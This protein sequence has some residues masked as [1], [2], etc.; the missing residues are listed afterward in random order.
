[1]VVHDELGSLQRSGELLLE[2]APLGDLLAELAVVAL[3]RAAA[4]PLAVV[5]RRIG[6]AEERLR[7]HPVVREEA[8]PDTHLGQMLLA[9]EL[10]R[11][12]HGPPEPFSRLHHLSGA[13]DVLE[14]NRELVA[15]EVGDRVAVPDDGPQAAGDLLEELIADGMPVRVVDLVESVEVQRQHR[16]AVAV[17]RRRPD[18]LAEPLL[19]SH[20]VG[21][22]GQRVVA[23]ELMKGLVGALPL[24]D[25]VEHHHV[26]GLPLP[27]ARGD[28]ELRDA[29]LPV[30]PPDGHL[31]PRFP[32][33]GYAEG[34]APES[35]TGLSELSLCGGIRV[36]DGAR[37]VDEEDTDGGVLH[38]LAEVLPTPPPLPLES[39]PLLGT[40]L[41]RL[42]LRL[43]GMG[44]SPVHES[45]STPAASPQNAATRA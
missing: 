25:V 21:Q 44:G 18:G 32:R 19:Q 39:A 7:V 30:A 10:D 35:L 24:R 4:E 40:V 13:V 9:G 1:M 26:A 41:A 15:A 37:L 22:L 2:D 43:V 29:D 45:I 28:P 3:D 5:H 38:D 33:Q 17:P 14:Q 12:G 11:L 27:L 16:E 42:L 31:R 23:G 8:V 20:A 6:A 34:S 36:E